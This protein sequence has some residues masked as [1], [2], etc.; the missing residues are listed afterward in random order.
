MA[1]LWKTS[2]LCVVNWAF[3]PPE[4]APRS[5]N[6]SK[7]QDKPGEMHNLLAP[8]P[9][10]KWWRQHR[11]PATISVSS[12]NNKSRTCWTATLMTKECSARASWLQLNPWS[13]QPATRRSNKQRPQLPKLQWTPSLV[14]RRLLKLLFLRQTRRVKAKFLL[15]SKKP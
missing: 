4:H 13:K 8:H 15:R 7:K 10:S 11:T 6:G 12:Y 3:L 2:V 1:C 9:S 5:S 14:L